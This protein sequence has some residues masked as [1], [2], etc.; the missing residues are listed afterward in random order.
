MNVPIGLLIQTSTYRVSQQ[1]VVSIILLGALI[2]SSS[3]LLAAKRP[4]TSA[5][6]IALSYFGSQG[7]NDDPFVFSPD[8]QFLAVY[9][10][11]G[12]L[13]L[14]RP[15]SILR[16]YRTEDIIRILQEPQGTSE[17]TP[18][19]EIRESTYRHGPIVTRIRWLQDSSGVAFLAKTAS[20]KNQLLLA[21]LRTK[22]IHELTR[23]DQCVT[24]FAVRTRRNFVYTALAQAPPKHAPSLGPS[25]IIGTGKDLPSLMFPDDLSGPG[26]SYR[27]ELWAV[28]SGRR[29]K[30][31]N[32]TSGRALIVYSINGKEP[33]LSPDGQSVVTVLPVGV[34][35]A[36]WE[37]LYPQAPLPWGSFRIRAG[38][39][40]LEG[41]H[42]FD[43]VE[44]YVLI[45]LRSGK[46][47]SLVG[48]PL[49]MNAA[50]WA[51]PSADWSSDGKSIALSGVFVR[52]ASP[53]ST[54]ISSPCV[55]VMEIKSL[56]F[57]C[58]ESIYGA[59]G[60]DKLKWHYVVRVRFTPGSDNHITI[61]SFWNEAGQNRSTTYMRESTGY[62]SQDTSGTDESK[63][64]PFGL[65]IK[66]SL[67][68]PPVLLATD[69]GT[70]VSRVIW[71]PNP[72]LRD[73]SL[74]EVSVFKWKDQSGHDDVAGLYKPP[75]YVPGRRYPLVIQTHGFE[76]DQFIPSGLFPTA[77]AAQELAAHGMLV[78]QV[79]GEACTFGVPEEASCSAANYEAAVNELVKA[80]IADRDKLGIIGF[81]RTCYYVLEELTAGSLHFKAASITDGIEYGYFQYLM[82]SDF[83]ENSFAK[84]ANVAVGAPPFGEG[85][86][87]WLK[88]SSAFRMD[89]VETPLQVVA[90]NNHLSLMSMWEPYAALRFLQKPV[91]LMIIRDSEHLMTNPE[92]RMISQGG[93]VDWF[94]FWLKGEEDSDPDKAQ[95]YVRWRELR[96]RQKQ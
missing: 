76:E 87:L 63:Q 48:A 12:R 79:R 51:V 7:L 68:D 82:S 80:G 65:S 54:S 60:D 45:D 55:A 86:T 43:L 31:K 49:A 39:Q 25:A 73:V 56:Q 46:I 44:E 96:Q 59:A 37:R 15:E 93:T 13:D 23:K 77:F 2:G 84:E 29:F 32:P 95:Q 83:G 67:N 3:P 71:D 9:T 1:S 33:S 34:V 21:D 91:D 47:Q 14:N 10:T 16:V 72:Q 94:R 61:D 41:P 69:N 26:T 40:D 64:Q 50:W 35:P 42:G 36:E 62:W 6:D 5:D 57:T 24:G 92:E 66:Q 90:L 17:P 53:D 4:F 18:V 74:G 28:V 22:V 52:M 75:D 38:R 27:N 19:W 89:R 78:L 85:L 70:G 20:G 11:H 30:L 8:H 81:S 58:L 88:R